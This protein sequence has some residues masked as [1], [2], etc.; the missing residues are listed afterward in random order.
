MQNVNPELLLKFIAHQTSDEESTMVIQ[1]LEENNLSL[2]DLE[3]ALENPK[4]IWIFDEI[5]AS[6]NWEPVKKKMV[7]KPKVLLMR[8]LLRVAASV[9]IL[10]AVAGI[11]FK[12][13]EYINRPLIVSNNSS[14]VLLYTLPDSSRVSLNRH[15]K[16]TYFSNF[17]KM[18]TVS[19][20][21][22]AFFEIK[23]DIRKPF[24]V[25]TAES[26]IKVL[27][28]SFSVVTNLKNTSVIVASGKVALYSTLQLADTLYLEKGEKGA[29]KAQ[30]R[31]LEKQRNKDLNFLAWKDH[32]LIFEKTPLAN[33]IAD[34]EKYFQIKVDVK[35]PE[36]YKLIYT[37]QFTNPSLSEVLKEMELVLNISSEVSGNYILLSLK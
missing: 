1:W 26:E 34:L 27:G 19:F 4:A 8:N 13:K 18:R 6:N 17:S 15:S 24:V 20:E 16:L 21:G 11:G 23:R 7:A 28:T 32:R 3:Y 33:V 37:S 10:V 9:L 36:I 12:V 25:K 22:E 14:E 31:S 5:Q 2:E 29:F 35:S 30:N